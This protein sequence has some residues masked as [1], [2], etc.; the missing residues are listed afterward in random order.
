MKKHLLL[1]AFAVIALSAAP[2]TAGQKLNLRIWNQHSEYKVY[3][4]LIQCDCVLNCEDLTGGSINARGMWPAGATDAQVESKDY[5]SNGDTCASRPSDVQLAF[6]TD[7]S[8]PANNTG[9]VPVRKYY[10]QFGIHWQEFYWCTSPQ[11]VDVDCV[12]T[13][14]D[15]DTMDIYLESHS[16]E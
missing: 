4:K 13:L 7:P 12:L 6:S 14:N 8:F 2:A 15:N 9:Y 5:S 10:P 11:L 16:S 1:F 3:W